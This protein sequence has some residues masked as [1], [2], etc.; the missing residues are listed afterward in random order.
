MVNNT[1]STLD[2]WL[3]EEEKQ[4]SEGKY[5]NSASLKSLIEEF[6]KK[7]SIPELQDSP[8]ISYKIYEILP[9][10]QRAIIVTEKAKV[11]SAIAR[12]LGGGK[13]RI[14]KTR[15]GNVTSFEVIWNS[16]YLTVIPLRGHVLDY[17]V[18]ERYRGD[19]RNSDPLELINP[20]SLHI[21]IKE[22]HIIDALRKIA[23]SSNLLILA[24]DA[25]EE[26]ANI[27]LEVFEII[28]E[29]KK[30]LKVVQMWFISLD[31]EE[32]RAAFL[33]PIEPKWSWAY[34]VKARRLLDAMIGFSATR[35]LTLNFLDV[36][37]K[38]GITKVFSI[39]RVQTPT[40]YTLYLREKEIETFKPRPYWALYVDMK[41]GDKIVRAFHEDSPFD[42]ESIA[43]NIYVKIKQAN[44]GSVT[45]IRK[46]TKRVRPPP[47]LNTTK[48]LVLLN[49]VLGL[50]SKEAMKILEDLYLN[51][52]ITYPRTETNKYPSNYNH[53]RNL[54]ALLNYSSLREVVHEI[55]QKGSKLRRN[56]SKLVGDH[57]PITPIAA[58]SSNTSLSK[59]HLMVYDIIVRRYL[60]LFLPDAKISRIYLQLN[61]YGEPFKAILSK[62]DELGFFIIYPYSKPKEDFVE[63]ELKLKE[64]VL[65]ERTYPPE[66]KFTQPPSRLTE[67]SLISIME[68]L[69]L[70]T[71]STRPDHIETLVQRGYIK[72]KGKTLYITRLGYSIISFLEEIWPDFVKPF[73]SAKVHVLM[74]KV[75]NNELEWQEMVESIR[76]KYLELFKKLREKIKAAS[77]EIRAAIRED[78]SAHKVLDC[79]K[80]GSPMVLKATKSTK[81][82]LISCINC[83]FSIIVPSAKS[84][85]FTEIKCIICGSTV[86]ELKRKHRTLYLCPTCWRHYGP[87]YKCP[88]RNECPIS[89]TLKKEEEKYFVGKCSCGGD[90][91]YFPEYRFVKCNKCDK[92]YY[93]PKKGSIR[94]LKKRCEKHNLRIFSIREKNEV[95]YH[96]IACNNSS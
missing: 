61:V 9:R 47:P 52:L 72:R 94:L 86:L 80:C 76:K 91:V 27:G 85:K 22:K 88:K 8:K 66:K 62:V 35:E 68:R 32:L 75:M 48:A 87:C 78:I 5:E 84:Y 1:G 82:N 11:A 14:I 38:T 58:P 12:A 40:L 65:I 43:Y 26:G 15:W 4:E 30:D 6:A 45:S 73:F 41:I 96:C 56:G 37:K 79:P 63:S 28:K 2:E 44:N 34:A 46:E 50:S 59:R 54:K 55:L 29:T 36:I 95:K 81:V 23:P 77:S 49:D 18:I 31:P 90:L 42:D 70:G 60:S 53:E 83:E 19:W 16:R 10:H 39:G 20:S 69:G 74:R 92:K 57:L 33:N 89:S 13:K 67:G 7:V 3:I 17:D 25:D 93:L 71:K 24:T 51:G 64:K 21:I